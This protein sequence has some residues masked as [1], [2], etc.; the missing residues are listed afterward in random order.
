MKADYA[1]RGY[2]YVK[3]Y[4]L[5]KL[6]LKAKERLERDILE[7]DYQ[8]WMISERP[9]DSEKELQREHHFAYAPRISVVVPVYKTPE[10]FLR[11]MVDSVLN[12]TY[13]N[14]E[15]CLADGSEEDHGPQKILEAYAAQDPRIR[16]EKLPKNLGIAGNTNAALDLATGEYVALLDHDDFLEEHALFELVKWLQTHPEADMIYTDEDKVSFD[17]ATFF[18]PHFKPDFNPD[19][20]RTNNYICHFLMVKRTLMEQAGKYRESFDGAQDYDFI[21]RCSE[22]AQEIEHIPRVLYH[23]RCHPT[24]TAGNPES[25]MYAYEAGR[26]ALEEHLKRTSMSAAV[27][28]MDNPGFYRVCYM[29][30]ETPKVTIVLLNVRDAGTLKRLARMTSRQAGY[31][32]YEILVLLENPKKNKIILNFIKEH[33]QTPIKVVYCNSACNKFVTFSSLAEKMDSD[34]LLFLDGRTGNITRGF[35]DLFLGSAQRA[36]IGAVGGRVYDDRRRLWYGIKVLGLKGTVGDA[37]EGLKA[38][39]TGYFHKAILQQNCHAVSGKAMMLRRELFLKAGGFSEDVEDRMKDVDLCLK[40]EKLGYRNV[41]E[42]GIAVILQ[43]HQRGRKQGARPAAQFA[44][45]WKSLLQMPDRFYNSNLSLD[46]TDFRIRDYH[47]K[48]D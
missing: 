27:Q 17:S 3:N 48:E 12:Q 47:R 33:R 46:N 24:S 34:Y 18:H 14:V 44:K 23:W 39:Y 40:L 13:G 37:F 29:P 4:G 15:L 25:K 20:L 8:Q 22:L 36:D 2:H 11:E 10:T 42:P 1:K 9:A 41:Y 32:N 5:S 31:S 35:M 30:A 7:R 19:L 6:Y 26:R 45:K 28:C 21:L 38:G 43:D 16:Y